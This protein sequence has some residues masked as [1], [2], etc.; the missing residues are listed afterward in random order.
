VGT[1]ACNT[2]S[3]GCYYDSLNVAITEPTEATLTVGAQ[4]TENL[5]INTTYLAMDCGNSANLGTFGPTGVCPSWY[6]GAQLAT[7][8]TAN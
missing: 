8:V 1:T 4:P 6:E 2:S 5:Y 3:G 7:E